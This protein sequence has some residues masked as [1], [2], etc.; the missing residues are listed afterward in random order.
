MKKHLLIV[1]GTTGIGRASVRLFCQQ[2]QSVSV[3]GKEMP[4]IE[5]RNQPGVEYSVV[6]L[7][8]KSA[9]EGVLAELLKARGKFSNIIFFQRY[10]GENTWEGDWQ[11]ILTATKNIIEFLVDDF[12]EEEYKSIVMVG[13][14]ASHLVA[15]EQSVSY[16]VTKAGMIQMMRYYATTLGKKGIRV[17]SV[18]P[19][20][21][22]KEEAKG[23]Y[24]QNDEIMELYREIIP[25][26]RM[27]SSEDIA[28]VIAFLCNEDSAYITGQDIV[29]DGGLTLSMQ[30]SIARRVSSA[31]HILVTQSISSGELK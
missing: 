9:T 11:I 1:G 16:H 7:N 5:D 28:R 31:R 24:A 8:D 12:T 2:G 22:M 13:S 15:E 10:R 20:V 3:L 27:A 17:N 29:V 21:V 19:G 30:A 26:G 25:L 14:V 4:P 23:F 6:D 18:S